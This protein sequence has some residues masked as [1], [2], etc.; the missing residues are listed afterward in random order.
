MRSFKYNPL[1]ITSKRRYI[2]FIKSA[3]IDFDCGG[4]CGSTGAWLESRV[5][6]LPT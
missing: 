2:P 3:V 4:Y 5:K 6:L 1:N